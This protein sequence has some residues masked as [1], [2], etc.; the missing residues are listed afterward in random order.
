MSRHTPRSTASTSC[1]VGRPFASSTPLPPRNACVMMSPPRSCASSVVVGITGVWGNRPRWTMI[2]RSP[3]SSLAA[4]RNGDTAGSPVWQARTL[5]P[6]MMSAQVVADEALVGQVD[7]ARVHEAEDPRAGVGVV[8]VRAARHLEGGRTAGAPVDDDRYAGVHADLV[9]RQA[10]VAQS[11][12]DVHVQVD[13]PRRDEQARAVD[14]LRVRVRRAEV[15]PHRGDRAVDHRDV[16]DLVD[17][18]GGVDHAAALQQ[19]RLH[20]GSMQHGA[21]LGTV[22]CI[23]VSVR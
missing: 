3:A 16:G 13:E 10:E 21:S 1:G 9:R 20:R 8:D 4:S 6:T 11:G 23:D 18:V 12:E 14:H 22:R 19:Q 17:E 2:G 7:L 5:N 15:G